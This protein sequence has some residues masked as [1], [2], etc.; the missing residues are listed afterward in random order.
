MAKVGDIVIVANIPAV[1]EKV[2]GSGKVDVYLLTAGNPRWKDMD[3]PATTTGTTGTTG[4]T[5]TAA[6]AGTTKG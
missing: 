2:H 6:T 1:V 3:D 5:A 4:T